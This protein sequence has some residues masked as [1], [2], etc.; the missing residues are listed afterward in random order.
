M[1]FFYLKDKTK[2]LLNKKTKKVMLKL[3]ITI[4]N[5]AKKEKDV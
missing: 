4:S 1:L 3:I 2:E 5:L